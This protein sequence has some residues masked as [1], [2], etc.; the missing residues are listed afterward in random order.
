M[1]LDFLLRQIGLG[2]MAYGSVTLLATV[3]LS[4]VVM[5]LAHK[6]YKN[7][8]DG[9][10]TFRQGF[11]IGFIMLVISGLF[12]AIFNFIYVHYIDPEF[13][14]RLRDQMVEFME[15]NN[16][17]DSEIAKGTARFEKMRGTLPETL[18]SG[19]TSGAVT[20]VVLGLIVSAF[21]R[22]RTPEFE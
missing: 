19:L 7:N 17:P 18:I 5:V 13:V 15:S 20:G 4:V 1:I 14:D 3:A 2:F 11:L 12:S 6:Y 10:M 22:Y 8:N 21:T 16:V 9:R